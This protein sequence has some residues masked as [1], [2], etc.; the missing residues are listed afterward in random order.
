MTPHDSLS[1]SGSLVEELFPF[2]CLISEQDNLIVS[3][4]TALTPLLP[5][6]Y[7]CSRFDAVF[8]IVRP[9]IQA[10]T[11]QTIKT[12]TR[13]C[14]I[15]EVVDT[16]IVL[17]GQFVIPAKGCLLFIGSILVQ[18]A[19]SLENIG[20]NLHSFAPFD[21]TPDFLILRKFREIEHKDI[22]KRTSML[23]ELSKSR[24]ELS[25]HAYTDELTKITNRRG[26]WNTGTKILNEHRSNKKS[27]LILALLD[28]DGFK[29]IND[30]HGH[31]A[32]DA[33]LC[34]A[35]ERIR[36]TVGDQGI[37]GRLGG[38]EFVLMLILEQQRDIKDHVER[39]LREINYPFQHRFQQFSIKASIGVTEIE[40]SDTLECAIHHADI[41]MYEGRKDTRGLITWYTAELAQ[42]LEEKKQLL[43]RLKEAINHKVIEPHF[44]P[45]ISF[46]SFKLSSFE[47]LARWNDPEIGIVR[48]DI[49]I[50]LAEELGM[51]DQLD[52]LIM[53][54]SLDQL[55][56][57]HSEGKQYSLHINVSAA[58]LKSALVDRVV[59]AISDRNIDAS[60][61]KLE[62]TETTI[63]ENTDFTISVLD[64]L[65]DNGLT[66]TLD[67]FGTGYSS[68]THI[69]DFP[70]SGLKI[71]RSFVA[72]AHTNEKSKALLRSV[73]T[74]AKYM[75]LHIIAEG[76]ESQEQFDF[77]RDIGCH[78]GQGFF[79]GKPALANTCEQLF[80]EQQDAAA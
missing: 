38:D 1:L 19:E 25:E 80:P 72:D 9:E 24:D 30:N 51:L 14:V 47:A 56:C 58:S 54:K 13:S 23:A 7:H 78:Y 6:N 62:L 79:I 67:D 29:A 66:L 45:I 15:I 42:R 55:A 18:N 75:D 36:D 3:V 64:S 40:P 34:A 60:Y 61:L 37:A 35:A 28:L 59:K 2:H 22:K 57:W 39:T 31:D 70:V 71:D 10:L 69:K 27:V 41:A 20:I 65:R 17:R 49:F 8:R 16:D 33:I 32:G 44:Q 21:L 43:V 68:L 50:A 63:L 77:L 73:A 46:E 48:P 74:I 76:I 12:H 52:H 11:A 26:F 5:Q 53:E 4:G